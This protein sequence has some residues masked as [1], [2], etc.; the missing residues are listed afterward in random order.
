MEL[1]LIF[2]LFVT[3]VS[4]CGLPHYQPLSSRVVNGEEAS[5]YSWPWQVSLES[6]YP[7]CGGTL[8]AANW[9]LTAAHCITFHTYRVVLAEHDMDTH[10]GPEQSI[11]VERMIIHPQWNDNCVSCG[12]DLA[13]LKLEKSAVLND[14]VQLACLPPQGTELAHGQACYVT[15]WGRL[16]SGGPR[17]AKLQQ[18]LL[19]VVEPSV[20]AGSDWW[21]SS[22]KTTMVCAG[23]DSKSAC[24]VNQTRRLIESSVQH[25]PHTSFS[26]AFLSFNK[27]TLPFESLGS[28]RNVLIFLRT[29]K[30]MKITLN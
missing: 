21:G 11:R 20:C 29:A 4:G 3:T 24:H 13:L 7:T 6:F 18:A 2:L 25:Q 26:L 9:V 15:G 30:F 12:N 14:K 10:E 27:L 19:P 28:L 23:G 1:L 16:S 5:P 22:V 8:I 17:P